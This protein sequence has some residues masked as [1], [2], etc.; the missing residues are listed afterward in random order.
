MMSRRQNLLSLLLGSGAVGLRALATG[1]PAKL[2]LAPRRVLAQVDAGQP[3]CPGAD[4]AQYIIFNTSGAGDPI[5]A[6]VPGTYEDAKIVHSA[7]AALAPTPL[8]LA[9][10]STTAAAPWATL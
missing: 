10:R 3:G 6:S 9:G 5:N 2:L 7:D 4:R 1:L 8:V